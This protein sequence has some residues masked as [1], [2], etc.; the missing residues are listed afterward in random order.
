MIS[1][2]ISRNKDNLKL[3]KTAEKEEGWHRKTT[4]GLG[5]MLLTEPS[6]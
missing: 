1:A 6:E 2:E 3:G 4:P 5:W